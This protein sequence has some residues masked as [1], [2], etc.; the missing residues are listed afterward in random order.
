M[1]PWFKMSY[2][3]L[4]EKYIVNLL[5]QHAMTKYRLTKLHTKLG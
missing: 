5:L 1:S 2:D 3:R 4:V